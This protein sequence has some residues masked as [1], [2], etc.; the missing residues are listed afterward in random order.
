MDSADATPLQLTPG[1]RTTADISLHATPSVHLRI[2][3]GAAESPTLG[4]MIFPHVSQRIFE[5]YVDSVTN[6]PDSWVAPGVIEISGLAPGHYIIEVPAGS[7]GNERPTAATGIATS[8]S[9]ATPTSTSRTH[10]ASS[11][12]AERFCSPR[13]CRNMCRCN[14]P[15][16]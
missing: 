12:S 6:A 14:S 9:P 4:R 16:P 13:T 15:I 7:G 5:G 8:T 11:M 3:T 1:E 10:P 2:H